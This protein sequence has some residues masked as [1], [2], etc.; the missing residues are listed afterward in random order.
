MQTK[1]R[2]GIIAIIGAVAGL[3]FAAGG[4][5]TAQAAATATCTWASNW[6]RPIA[7]S[8]AGRVTNR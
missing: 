7:I 5:G 3:T 1:S 8:S 2:A 4:A 6:S